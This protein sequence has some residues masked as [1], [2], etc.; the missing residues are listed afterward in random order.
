MAFKFKVRTGKVKIEGTDKD[1]ATAVSERARAQGGE[2][3]FT[4]TKDNKADKVDKLVF[5]GKGREIADVLAK[6]AFTVSTD[7]DAGLRFEIR[8]KPMTK[9]GAK[10]IAADAAKGAAKEAGK[11]AGKAALHAATH[12]ATA[13]IDLA[14]GAQ[15]VGKAAV[16]AAKSGISVDVDNLQV[17]WEARIEINS[18]SQAIDDEIVELTKRSFPFGTEAPSKQLGEKF[19]DAMGKYVASL[20]NAV[21]LVTGGQR[22]DRLLDQEDVVRANAAAKEKEGKKLGPLEKLA[23]WFKERRRRPGTTG[24]DEL[25][26]S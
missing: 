10:Q 18:G 9:E 17:D 3:T 6:N 4:F 11:V 22:Y 5:W 7:Y 20:G 21:Q 25:E 14:Q 15:Q 26:D 23:N 12:G 13:A 8:W 2:A 24:Y 1:F 19:L 16:E